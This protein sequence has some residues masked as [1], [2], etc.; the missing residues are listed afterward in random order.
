MSLRKIRTE[1]GKLRQEISA[2][3]ATHQSGA[4]ERFA[5]LIAD[6]YERLK[7]N[8]GYRPSSVIE[9]LASPHAADVD[10]AIAVIEEHYGASYAVA[11]REL[12]MLIKEHAVAR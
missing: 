5:D 2:R 11:L 7:N 12:L 1:L 10:E 3:A 8:P 6:Y 4:A 9:K